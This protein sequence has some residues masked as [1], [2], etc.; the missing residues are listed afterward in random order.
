MQHKVKCFGGGPLTR[1]CTVEGSAKSWLPEH[2]IWG[3]ALQ[4]LDNEYDPYSLY[5]GQELSEARRVGLLKPKL[6]IEMYS[7]PGIEILC[8]KSIPEWFVI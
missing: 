6:Y 3:G 2:S 1:W 5:Q 8:H 4:E 7:Q